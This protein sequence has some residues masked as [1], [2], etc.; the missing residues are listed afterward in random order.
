MKTIGIVMLGLSLLLTSVLL[1]DGGDTTKTS[2][3]KKIN[4]KTKT[5]TTKSK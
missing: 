2:K 4:K 5:T 1:A 3:S